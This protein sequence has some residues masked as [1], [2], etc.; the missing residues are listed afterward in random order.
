M[1]PSPRTFVSPPSITVL[2]SSP[3]T[4]EGTF[5]LDVE[6]CSGGTSGD[7]WWEQID[8]VNRRLVPQN[9]AMLANLHTASFD[10]VSSQQLRSL[11]Y[12]STP[13]DGSNNAANQLIRGTVVA[14]RTRGGHYGKVRVDSYGYKLGVTVTTYA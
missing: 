10:S 5:H 13:I 14:V 8:A 3:A 7:V 2:C 1:P 6:S 4:V 12:S 9:G 11:S